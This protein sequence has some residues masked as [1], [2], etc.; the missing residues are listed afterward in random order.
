[1][2]KVTP[3]RRK[4]K[5]RRPGRLERCARAVLGAGLLLSTSCT[6][7]S[8]VTQA[9]VG[10]NDLSVRARDIDML[11]RERHVGPRMRRLLSEV[12]L[13]KR[14]GEKYGLTATTNYTKYVSVNGPAVVWVVSASE[15]LRFH[16]KSWELPRS[17]G[18]S[19]TWGGSR[20]PS[21]KRSPAIFGKKGGTSM[22]A[23]S[24]AYSTQGY[25]EDPVGLVDD[26]SRQGGA[27]RARPA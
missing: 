4:R 7:L 18:A 20:N 1:M 23:A 24:A 13:M 21:R 3:N 6:S 12:A 8:Y 26:L 5:P 19:R 27:R 9:A 22:S 2:S 10:Q 15:A 17:S 11:V 16:S 14:F 25:F